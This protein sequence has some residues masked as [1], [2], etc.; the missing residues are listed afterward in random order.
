MEKSICSNPLTT[1][2]PKTGAL[3][4]IYGTTIQE[5]T[6][7]REILLSQ[8]YTSILRQNKVSTKNLESRSSLELT[9]CLVLFSVLRQNI[10][11]LTK[12]VPIAT[13][14]EDAIVN[15]IA[16]KTS[17]YRVGCVRHLRSNIKEWVDSYQGKLYKVYI[18]SNEGK[19]NCC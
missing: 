1:A 5:W 11:G 18:T 10:K 15:A 4:A 8:K 13:D 2:K 6:C 9:V 16:E 7:Q 14:E 3:M 17:L 19:S 12:T